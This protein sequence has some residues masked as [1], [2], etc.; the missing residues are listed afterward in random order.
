MHEILTHLHTGS[1]VLD[2]GSGP[3]SFDS[4][5]YPFRTVRLDP[6]SLPPCSAAISV[7]AD[8]RRMPFPSGFFD[9]IVA[10]H[11]LEHVSD[12]NGCLREIARVLAPGGAAF[13]SVPGSTTV[14]DRLYR[15]M[16]GGGGHIN[17]FADP[18]ALTELLESAT[19]LR[20]RA[21]R[22]LLTSLSFLDRRNGRSRIPRKAVLFGSG[23]ASA[24][25]AINFLLRSLDSLFHTR[26][27]LYGWAIYLG[28]LD[29][30]VG[31]EPWAN[32]C[33]RC[34]SGHSSDGLLRRGRVRRRWGIIR[35]YTCAHCG[36]WN[37]FYADRRFAHFH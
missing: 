4:S 24:L 23:H 31:T 32:V 27:A 2:L 13:V 19:G 29:E 12:L 18:Q 22:P 1:R 25:H 11:S 33:I 20:V 5:L 21:V 10:N 14:A 16:A 34:G 28:N 15:W 6:A 17:D 3:G 30:R 26:T 37:V 35:C 8:G 36:A 9:A 7:R